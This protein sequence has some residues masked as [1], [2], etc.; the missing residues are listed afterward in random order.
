MSTPGH[1][2]K[3][4]FVK[5]ISMDLAHGPRQRPRV[6]IAKVHAQTTHKVSTWSAR[7][8]HVKRLKFQKKN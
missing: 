3:W 5:Q 4:T 2:R 1:R 7:G 8:P 6:D